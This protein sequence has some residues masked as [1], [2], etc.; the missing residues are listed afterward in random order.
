MNKKIAVAASQ[1]A[2]CRAKWLTSAA[3]GA[4]AL[5]ALA[6][7]GGSAYASSFTPPGEEAGLNAANPLP[8][9]VYFV[10]IFGTGGD[11]LVDDKKSNLTFDVPVIVWAT[12]WQTEFLGFKGRFE[13]IGAA[14]IIGNIGLTYC[15]T[16]GVNPV[17]GSS[18]QGVAPPF[19]GRDITAFYNPLLLV[20][21]A[22][23]LGGG[24]GF[25]SFD[26]GYA[27]IDN[28]LRGTNNIWVYNNRS[29][30]GWTGTLFPGG[31]KDSTD[32]IKGT[33]AIENVYGVTGT[34][35]DTHKKLLPD[36]DN[37]NLTAYVTI[38]KW[39]IGLVGFYSTDLEDLQSGSVPSQQCG[40]VRFNP[41]A[42]CGQSRAG[43]GP[44]I[45]Y[46]F[47][48]ISVQVNYTWDVY[49]QNYRNING[50][51]MNI[52]QFWLK[53]TIPLWNPPK[54]EEE[55]TTYKQ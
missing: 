26:G 35:I 52:K 22:W 8:E 11:Y 39:D 15:N 18:I 37:V 42:R 10:N 38:G 24:W 50:S 9:G 2:R 4:L 25:S 27:P 53:T 45:E 44:L 29:W 12:P 7:C 46:D 40:G 6:L 48:G 54:L 30:L 31:M 13:V 55:K 49:E 20:G 34:N 5:G 28:E 43:I 32:A 19:G 51:D 36:Y 3:G 33:F 41:A 21:F 17:T 1:L 16:C 23:D 14:P 47:T